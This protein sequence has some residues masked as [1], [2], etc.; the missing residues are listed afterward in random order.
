[1]KSIELSGYWV[2]EINDEHEFR[3][4]LKNLLTGL[5]LISDSKNGNPILTLSK[6]GSLDSELEIVPVNMRVSALEDIDK[7]LIFK[8]RT[9]PLNIGSY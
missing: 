5:Y 7:K 3:M 6:D 2:V 1:M 9:C 8:L 4:K